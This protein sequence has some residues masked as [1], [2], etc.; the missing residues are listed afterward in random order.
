MIRRFVIALLLVLLARLAPAGETNDALPA[1]WFPVGE[2]L[3]YRIFW[4][5]IPVGYV[6]VTSQWVE[7][8]G[9]TLLA[10]RMRTRTGDVLS[11]VYPV[12]D[13]VETVIDPATFLP[14]RCTKT[15]REGRY[16]CDE[17]T[18]FDHASRIAH[19]T[20][21]M[22]HKTK[23]I[24]IEPDTLDLVA[25][26]YRMR[27]NRFEPGTK[28]QYKV[29]ADEKLYSLE[30]D[31]DRIESFRVGD[32]GWV[33]SVKLEPKASFGGLFVRKG[34]LWMW[35]SE[36]E[37]RIA[38]KVAAQVVVGKVNILLV[39]VDGPGDDRWTKPG[40]GERIEMKERAP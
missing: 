30:V 27:L 1:L 36:D 15:L 33:S 10:I 26:M 5:V 11:K 6:R 8:D 28:T 35:V 34:R 22:N 17:V 12:D 31:A 16:R 23:E 20:S 18:V 38:T 32:Y 19:W 21:R 40:V 9:R 24:P 39:G 25:F 2:G 4:G 37:R 29:M 14:L 13:L 7:E 3:T